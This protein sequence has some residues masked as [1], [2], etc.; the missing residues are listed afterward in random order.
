VYS[1]E[2]LLSEQGDKIPSDLRSQVEAKIGLLKTALNDNDVS[3]MRQHSEQLGQL[4][5]QVGASMYQGAGPGATAPPEGEA[6]S[7]DG[8]DEEVI[9]AEFSET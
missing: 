3:G 2:K 8:G 4:L 9:D 7:A 6:P 1:A 5:Q